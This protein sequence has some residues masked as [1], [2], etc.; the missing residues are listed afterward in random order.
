MLHPNNHPNHRPT[1][2]TSTIQAKTKV[3]S[4]SKAAHPATKTTPDTPTHPAPKDPTAV[5]VTAAQ[6]TAHVLVNAATNTALPPRKMKAIHTS[7]PALHFVNLSSTHSATT[8]E[9]HTGKASMVSL[10]IPTLFLRLKG[11]MGS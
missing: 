3:D 4:A 6:G 8:K 7:T 1:Q 10:F 9:L 11:Q 2:K 5:T